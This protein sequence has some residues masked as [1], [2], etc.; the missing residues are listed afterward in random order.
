MKD[1]KFLIHEIYI[2][3]YT[4]GRADGLEGLVIEPQ[5]VLERFLMDQNVA[6]K[7]SEVAFISINALEEQAASFH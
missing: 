1:L 4:Q 6:R 7:F 5:L 3:A 2:A